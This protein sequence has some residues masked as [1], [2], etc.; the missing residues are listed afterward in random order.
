MLRKLQIE[1]VIQKLDWQLEG[2]V[3]RSRRRE[4]RKELR[5][6]LAAAAEEVGTEE[7]IRRLGNVRDLAGEYLEF[8]TGKIHVRTG[9]YAALVAVVFLEL[10]GLALLDGFREGFEAAGGTGSSHYSFWPY[11]IE[12]SAGSQSAWSISIAWPGLFGVPLLAFLGW[13]RSWRLLARRRP[14]TQE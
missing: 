8:E 5:A 12:A 7:A 13:A 10:L 14:Q 11:S 3:P 1:S 4:I 6:N 2:R 9:L